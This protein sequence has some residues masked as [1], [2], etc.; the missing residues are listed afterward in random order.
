MLSITNQKVLDFYSKHPSLSFEKIN[1]T[2]V[3]MLE[4]IVDTKSLDNILAK[5]IV[6]N[7]DIIKQ[8]LSTNKHE[9]LEDLK[10]ILHT[11]TNE[12]INKL[13]KEHT[14]FIQD[15]TKL[16]ITECIPKNNDI[17]SNIV[18]LTELR[19]KEHLNEIKNITINNKEKQNRLD[20]EVN[21]LIHKMD[22]NIGKGK[23][24]ENS[25]ENMLNNIFPSAEIINSSTTKESADYILRRPGLH[26][27]RFENKNY[28][29]NV[30]TTQLNKFKRD[31]EV[32]NSSGVMLCQTSGITSKNNFEFEIFNNNIYIYLHK[33]NYDPDK[34]KTAVD[35]IDHLK[36]EIS[37]KEINKDIFIDRI[38]F[39]KINAEFI[40]IIEKRDNIIALIK[41]SN[42][43]I[44][45]DV[46]DIEFPVLMDF[47]NINSGSTESKKFIC[48]YCGLIPDKNNQK[49]LQSHHR[50]CKEKKIHDEKGDASSEELNIF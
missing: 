15:R 9:Y 25:L 12:N 23:I 34:I 1:V 16:I 42:E 13:I 31:M 24:S 21:S 30:P 26:D 6:D 41:K 50:W 11:N 32:N 7:F 14:G 49:A 4:N 43:K 29:T 22:S 48:E 37:N 2:V 20:D 10:N 38:L 39:A 28:N 8:S 40:K 47:I 45:K 35:M 33:V 3:E 27:I 46:R 18:A 17:I 19:L 44:I 36:K 5:Q